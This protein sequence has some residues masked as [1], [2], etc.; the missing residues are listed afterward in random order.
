MVSIMLVSEQLLGQPLYYG[1]REAHGSI[2]HRTIL[3]LLSIFIGYSRFLCCLP[4][5]IL[6]FILPPFC[7]GKSVEQKEWNP[8]TS[9]LIAI[10]GEDRDICGPPSQSI[11]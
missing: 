11:V 5:F 2:I 4:I 1:E 10:T 6:I 8:V 9:L 3:Y 7:R